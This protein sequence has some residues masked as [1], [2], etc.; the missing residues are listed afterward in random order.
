MCSGSAMPYR[1][2]QRHRISICLIICIGVLGRQL[3]LNAQ[4]LTGQVSGRVQDPSGQMIAGAGVVLT[5]N[6]TGQ[7]RAAKTN[8]S[9]EFLF[10][11]VI[12]RRFRLARRIGRIQ[13]F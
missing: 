3:V 2:I 7:R 11:E 6:V 12:S 1:L 13:S 10:T 9:G 4:G 8:A 5:S